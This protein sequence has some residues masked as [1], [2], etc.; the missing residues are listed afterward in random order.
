MADKKCL[1]IRLSDRHEGLD[2][3]SK[4]SRHLTL[5]FKCDDIQNAYHHC[6][7]HA[8]R[9]RPRERGR[10]RQRDTETHRH[11]GLDSRSK[12]S[13]HLTLL[14]KCDDIQNAYHHCTW[15]AERLRPRE[16]G[17]DR[18]RDTQT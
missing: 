5:L 15:H 2:S 10:D 7:W 4:E 18:Q 11:E 9:L 1:E 14:F 6:T 12:E 16:R 17:R 8:E 13:R 3:R